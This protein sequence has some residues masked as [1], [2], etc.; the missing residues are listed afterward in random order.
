MAC[1][2]CQI[3]AGMYDMTSTENVKTLSRRRSR[4]IPTLL[5]GSKIKSTGKK[6][7]IRPES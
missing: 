6:K 1:E 2:Q 5:P 4:G 3:R 7:T